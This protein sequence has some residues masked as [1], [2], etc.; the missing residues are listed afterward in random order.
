MGL[1]VSRKGPVHLR[2]EEHILHERKPSLSGIPVVAR[3]VSRA[4]SQQGIW[5]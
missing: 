3:Q 2:R 4:A 1:G 5:W